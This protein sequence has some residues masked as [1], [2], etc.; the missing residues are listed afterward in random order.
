MQKD[1]SSCLPSLNT[2]ESGHDI[3]LGTTAVCGNALCHLLALLTAFVCSIVLCVCVCAQVVL[4]YHLWGIC[5]VFDHRQ[6]SPAV[7]ATS[8]PAHQLPAHL[9]TNPT[10]Q[11]L[12]HHVWLHADP[13]LRQRA[14]KPFSFC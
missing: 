7:H 3:K 8:V 4:V 6:L 11:P 13:L 9:P 5:A 1:G 10:L 14:G 12:H 2:Y